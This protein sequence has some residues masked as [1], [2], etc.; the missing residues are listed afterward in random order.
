MLIRYELNIIIIKKRLIDE[1]NIAIS[2]TST[3][4]STECQIPD[5]DKQK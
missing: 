3:C 2:A 4:I 5:K 1:V